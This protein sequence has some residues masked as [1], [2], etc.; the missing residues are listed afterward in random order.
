MKSIKTK[1]YILR[2]VESNDAENIYKILS[3][4]K[5]I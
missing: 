5:V 4:E 3:N 1:R 2:T